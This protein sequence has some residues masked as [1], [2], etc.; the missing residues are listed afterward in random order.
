[1]PVVWETLGYESCYRIYLRDLIETWVWIG[2]LCLN[3]TI[4][5]PHTQQVMAFV[6]IFLCW[7]LG[8]VYSLLFE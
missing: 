2:T 3:G 5:D 6:L 4:S 8:I 7:E 1:M